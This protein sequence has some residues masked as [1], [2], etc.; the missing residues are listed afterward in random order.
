MHTYEIIFSFKTPDSDDWKFGTTTVTTDQTISN[1]Q[2]INDVCRQIGMANGYTKVVFNGSVPEIDNLDQ[3]L[4]EK[5]T[6]SSGQT[7]DGGPVEEG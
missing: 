1:R 5:T 6:N 3:L 7:V 2:G 4:S